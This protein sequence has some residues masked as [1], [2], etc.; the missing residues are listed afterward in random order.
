MINKKGKEKST[1]K[2]KRLKIIKNLIF[3][4]F[5]FILFIVLSILLFQKSF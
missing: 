5:I 4:K 3:D 2:E 1:I